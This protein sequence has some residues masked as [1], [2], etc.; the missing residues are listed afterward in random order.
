MGQVQKRIS[1]FYSLY[2]LKLIPSRVSG[3]GYKIS[4]VCPSVCV[5]VRQLVS[6]LT[7]EPFDLRMQNLVEG[8]TLTKSR[9]SSKVKVKG[10][11]RHFKKRD[12]RT[13]L[14]C[15]LYRLDRAFLL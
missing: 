10:Q 11:G 14:W 4:P 2:D 7:A 15:D 8:F 13:F 12:F 1:L 6:T 3:R 5:C 9:T